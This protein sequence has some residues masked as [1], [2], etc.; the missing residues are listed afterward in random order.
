MVLYGGY[1]TF[2]L[3]CSTASTWAFG[4]YF[5]IRLQAQGFLNAT[6]EGKK[7]VLEVFVAVG[8]TDASGEAFIIIFTYICHTSMCSGQRSIEM[9]EIYLRSAPL[10]SVLGLADDH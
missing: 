4:H 6:S 8:E 1:L 9:I 3:G 10:F 5:P 2:Y 7:V